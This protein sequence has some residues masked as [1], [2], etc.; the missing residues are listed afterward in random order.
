MM[1]GKYDIIDCVQP[2]QQ[3]RVVMLPVSTT[4]GEVDYDYMQYNL[5]SE[6]DTKTEVWE[7]IDGWEYKPFNI[8]PA[9]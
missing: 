7:L 9:T 6:A 5:R 1:N 2:E 8:V 3:Q 4:T